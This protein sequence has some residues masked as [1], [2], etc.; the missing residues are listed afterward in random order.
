M[1]S[2]RRL[3]AGLLGLGL[4]RAQGLRAEGGDGQLAQ[5]RD[6]RERPLRGGGQLRYHPHLPLNRRSP[7]PYP[8]PSPM[9]WGS[10]TRSPAGVGAPADWAGTRPLVGGTSPLHKSALLRR[11]KNPSNTS[12]KAPQ[13]EGSFFGKRQAL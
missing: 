1:L 12:A 2:R 7:R 6:L 13:G 11:R 9:G 3:L 5:R 10:L 8:A 4:S